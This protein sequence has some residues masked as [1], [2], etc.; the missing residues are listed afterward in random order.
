MYVDG[1]EQRGA[2][3]AEVSVKYGSLEGTAAITVWMPETPLRV[4]LEDR[5]LSQVKGW[6]VSQQQHEL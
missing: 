2:L 3:S 4:D 6:R 5:R 1:S